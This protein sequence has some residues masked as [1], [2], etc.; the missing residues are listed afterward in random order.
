M[1]QTVIKLHAWSVEAIQLCLAGIA[2]DNL[3]RFI[4]AII[5]PI[6]GNGTGC[7]T[8]GYGLLSTS[9]TD[10]FVICVTLLADLLAI[11]AVDLIE[12]LI[13]LE[14]F[15]HPYQ[16][17]CFVLT[18]HVLFPN[19]KR[20]FAGSGG[21]WRKRKPVLRIAIPE[22]IKDIHVCPQFRDREAFSVSNSGTNGCLCVRPM[23]AGERTPMEHPCLDME[24]Q[25]PYPRS[26]RPLLTVPFHGRSGR[27][28]SFVGHWEIREEKMKCRIET[29]SK[30]ST[31]LAYID[32]AASEDELQLAEERRFLEEI[33]PLADDSDHHLTSNVQMRQKE[34]RTSRIGQ[35]EFNR[36]REDWIAR[37]AGA[38]LKLTE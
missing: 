32:L 17:R 5:T 4:H 15:T 6:I 2:V 13:S 37:Q 10:I 12:G 9:Y 26:D 24:E 33:A 27:T 31:G 16:W 20:S 1:R 38:P 25:H 29:R 11:Y 19:K 36:R 22:S 21:R 30:D 8:C 3:F 28:D 18:R 35:D 34:N 7:L 14:Q 23:D